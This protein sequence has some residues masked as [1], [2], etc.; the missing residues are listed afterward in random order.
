[1]KKTIAVLTVLVLLCAA[2]S[3]FADMVIP[4]MADMPGV[5]IEDGE[6]VVEESA[7][8]G[9]W[10]LNA[11]FDTEGYVDSEKLFN[12]Y[13]FNYEPYVIGGG[14]ILQDQQNEYG[15]FVT[16]EIPYT[17]TAGQLQGEDDDGLA[18]VV[19]AL[20]DGNIVITVFYPGEDGAVLW[21]AMYMMHP[22]TAE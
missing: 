13:N 19:E 7:F 14:K 1:M 10:V 8:E 6:T 16:E 18:F 12:K 22:E 11:A 5:I 15:E 21:L 20:E 3:A 2:C 4:T 9:T 17:L